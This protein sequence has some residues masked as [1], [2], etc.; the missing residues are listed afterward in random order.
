M[1][2]KYDSINVSGG[3]YGILGDRSAIYLAT[4]QLNREF[5][6]FN[7]DLSVSLASYSLPIAPQTMTCYGDSIYLLANRAPFIYKITFEQ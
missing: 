1:L 3:V 2:S 7:K 6:I 5:Q 4:R